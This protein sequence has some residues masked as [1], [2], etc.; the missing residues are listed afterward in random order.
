MKASY[1]PE[2]LFLG[3]S[4]LGLLLTACTPPTP[5]AL[6]T[7]ALTATSTAVAVRP[8]PTVT[9]TPTGIPKR[10]PVSLPTSQQTELI[11]WESLPDAQARALAEDIAAFQVEFPRYRVRQKQYGSPESFLTSLTVGE[12]RFDLVL[13]SST[14]LNSLWTGNHLAPMSNFFPPTFIDEFVPITLTGGGREEELWGLP[15]TAGFHLLLFYNR[16]L[17]DTPPSSTDQ[18]FNQSQSLQRRGTVRWGVGVNSFDPLWLVPWLAPEQNWPI[19][20]RGQAQLDIPAMESALTLFLKWHG[21]N[22]DKINPRAAI[23]PVVTYEEARN[24]FLQG[25]AAMMIDGDWA[26]VELAGIDT[27][28]WGVAPLPELSQDE[29]TLQAAP[30][31]LARYWSISRS[32]TGNRAL[33]V[34]ALVEYLTRPERQL[35]STEQFG[36]LPSRRQALADPIIANNPVLRISAAQMQAGRGVPLG[37]NANAILEAMRDPLQG[38]LDGDLTP[39]QATEMMQLQF[40]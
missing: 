8:T 9:T 39:A 16:D 22:G 13:A 36:L 14:L 26:I 31:V 33:A 32:T 27:I 6:P 20:R 37:I 38:A 15:D 35:A 18:L 4:L 23:A 1:L 28:N 24:L 19:D 17:V 11:V 34:A 2:Y 3:M 12:I 40:D 21:R 25:H 29:K 10:T 7:P 30:L 5:P